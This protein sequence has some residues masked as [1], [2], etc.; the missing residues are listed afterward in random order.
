MAI[1]GS[2]Q[3]TEPITSGGLE[4]NNVQSHTL[5][6]NQLFLLYFIMGTVGIKGPRT[7]V[8]PWALSEDI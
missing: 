7:Y 4:S 3:V 8:E 6:D 5:D 1:D 2:F